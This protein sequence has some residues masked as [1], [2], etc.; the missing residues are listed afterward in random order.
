MLPDRTAG[1]DPS[2]VSEL[3]AAGCFSSSPLGIELLLLAVRP[4]W[5]CAPGTDATRCWADTVGAS[6]GI[7]NA[8]Q[9]CPSTTTAR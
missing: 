1:V 3:R 4:C 9:V 5:L 8:P 6:V 7:H 2:G